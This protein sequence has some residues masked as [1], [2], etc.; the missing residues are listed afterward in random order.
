M[1]SAKRGAECDDRADLEQ[2][3][4]VEGGDDDENQNQPQQHVFI[5]NRSGQMA[6]PDDS[7]GSA[8]GVR[9]DRFS[10]ILVL[11]GWKPVPHIIS[12]YIQFSS[13]KDLIE[14]SREPVL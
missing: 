11:T 10:I 1:T 14:D 2:Q 12:L 3:P 9:I 7:K 5:S 4:Q 8:V 13:R 6:T